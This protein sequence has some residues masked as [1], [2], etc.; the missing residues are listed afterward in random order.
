MTMVVIFYLLLFGAEMFVLSL[1]HQSLC[2]I[3]SMSTK[4]IV[5]INKNHFRILIPKVTF[6]ELILHRTA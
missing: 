3:A 1:P 2:I 6:G 4:V 5:V